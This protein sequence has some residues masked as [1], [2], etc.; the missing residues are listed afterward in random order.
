VL[1]DRIRPARVDLIEAQAL[2][3]V[4]IIAN[5]NV[6]TTSNSREK[7]SINANVISCLLTFGTQFE[8]QQLDKEAKPLKFE[9]LKNELVLL[10]SANRRKILSQIKR[11]ASP[12]NPDDSQPRAFEKQLL[13]L[14]AC[15]DGALSSSQSTRG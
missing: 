10:D 2:K 5:E 12:L 9:L 14:C 11:I 15:I 4:R 1:M 6:G 13:R 7:I 8:A 3:L